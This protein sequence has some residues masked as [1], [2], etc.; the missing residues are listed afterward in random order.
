MCRDDSC[1]CPNFDKELSYSFLVDCRDDKKVSFDSVCRFAVNECSYGVVVPHSY[2]G[3]KHK[4]SQEIVFADGRADPFWNSEFC[5]KP[6]SLTDMHTNCDLNVCC[7]CLNMATGWRWVTGNKRYD[8]SK[9][10]G[11]STRVVVTSL[12]Q[13]V[14]TRGAILTLINKPNAKH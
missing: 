13:R 5:A 2:R 8:N 12:M 9:S 11:I 3:D 7:L 1:P 14:V 6:R 4:E 10:N